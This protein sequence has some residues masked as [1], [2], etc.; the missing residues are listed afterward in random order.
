MPQHKV[1]G[2]GGGEEREGAEGWESQ[3]WAFRSVVGCL[4][5]DKLAERKVLLLRAVQ[6]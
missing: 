6:R 1:V 5:Q 2:N 4:S 3:V